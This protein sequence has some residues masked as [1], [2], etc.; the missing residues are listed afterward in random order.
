M[1][2]FAYYL[3]KVSLC[4]GLLFGY[5]FFMLRNKRFHQYNRFYLLSAVILSWIIPLAKIKFWNDTA[6][7]EMPAIKLLKVVATRDA[8]VE[9]SLKLSATFWNFDTLALVI[10]SLISA[11][12]FIS[13]IAGIVRIGKLIRSNTNKSWKNINF[14]FTETKGTPFSFFKYIFWNKTIDLQ[15]EEGKHILQHELTH[16]HE[17]HSADKLFLNIALV[18]GWLNPFFWLVRKELNMIHEFIADEKAISDGDTDSFSAMLLKTAYPQHSF[19]LAN[20]FFHSPIKRRLI[21]FTNSKKPSYSY[22]RKLMI[23]PLLTLVAVVFVLKLKG[24]TSK[25]NNNGG[26]ASATKS[27]KIVIANETKKSNITSG[28]DT[29]TNAKV[30][31]SPYTVKV[32]ADTAAISQSNDTA[33][34]NELIAVYDA[35]ISSKNFYAKNITAEQ[36]SISD[37]LLKKLASEKYKG[38]QA[39]PE[40]IRFLEDV[41]V[42][43]ITEEHKK[44]KEETGTN[45]VLEDLIKKQV[46]EEQ[47]DTTKPKFNKVFTIVE[48]PPYYSKG[49]AAF[50]D[51]IQKNMQYPKE[52]IENKK[53][54]AVSIKFIID[55]DGKL[56]DFKKVSDVGLGLE[57]E[58]I[59]LLKNSSGWTPG[60]QNG[61]KVP[62][63]IVQQITF[64]L[65]AEEGAK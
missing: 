64:S 47:Q 38:K 12:F 42:K 27:E 21:M 56:S 9:E 54:G 32:I 30:K 15:T 34:S 44:V 33:L 22:L 65:P 61:H 55:E 41:I 51:Y 45:E 60:I 14:I 58:A 28:E 10:F 31:N 24:Q 1:L 8:I 39:N 40:L 2:T 36:R 53:E 23:L 43:R 25:S 17:K 18:I 5:Y 46:K 16:M 3:L 20:S 37:F 62:V 29:D 49:M 59:R 13:L 52:A 11:A 19:V 7:Q 50:A 35:Q 6:Q 26:K 48:N 63:E 4:S 57:E